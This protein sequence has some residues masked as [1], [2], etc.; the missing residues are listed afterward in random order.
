MCE[1]EQYYGIFAENLAGLDRNDIIEIAKN[2][3]GKE[4]KEIAKEVKYTDFYDLKNYEK[5]KKQINEKLN[6]VGLQL[7]DI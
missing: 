6:K 3:I 2:I 7:F 5:Y 4:L 1:G